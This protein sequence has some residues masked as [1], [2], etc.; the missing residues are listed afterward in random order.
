MLH[1]KDQSTDDQNQSQDGPLLK[2]ATG[3]KTQIL[4]F[5]TKLH[6]QVEPFCAAFFTFLMVI[7]LGIERQTDSLS[8]S[9]SLSVLLIIQ[10]PNSTGRNF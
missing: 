5:L 7:I 4:C 8:H 3:I 1:S 2:V 9:L 6:S 10:T